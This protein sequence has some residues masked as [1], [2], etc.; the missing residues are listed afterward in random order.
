M[1]R[2]RWA[3][4]QHR[5]SRGYNCK[6]VALVP[7]PGGGGSLAER[8]ESER[9]GVTVTPNKSIE[10]FRK[11]AA[12]RMRGNATAAEARLWFHLRR[13]PMIGSHFRRQVI[14]GPYIA[15]FACMATKIII[16]VDGSQH[17]ENNNR[18]ADTKRTQWLEAEGYRVLRYWNNDISG[19]IDGVLSDIH[20]SLGNPQ[21]DLP[22][23]KHTRRRKPFH[24]TPLA[25]ASLGE[26][27][28]P[29]RGG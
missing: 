24:P 15:D 16:E 8:S 12:R 17:G 23:F 6:K 4:T 20:A 9:G 1:A 7:S 2:I 3:A 21:N 25:F 29:S 28:S 27:P 11:S 5:R 18:A 13:H 26:R 14:I 10:S 22:P 19:N